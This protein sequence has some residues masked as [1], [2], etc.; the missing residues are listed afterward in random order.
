[1]KYIAKYCLSVKCYLPA[2]IWS[3]GGTRLDWGFY[4][5]GGGR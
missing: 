2:N 1:M 3:T 4:A 5:I